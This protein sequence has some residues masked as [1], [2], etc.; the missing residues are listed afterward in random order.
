MGTLNRAQV[1]GH[2]GKDAELRYT[3]GGQPVASFSVATTEAWNDK[4]GQRQERTTWHRIVLWGKRAEG[5]QAYLVKG[6][7]V[8]VEGRL[9]ASEY[10]DREGVKRTK[11]EI[12]ASDVQLLGGGGAASGARQPTTPRM[13]NG[14]AARGTS[15][16][17]ADDPYGGAWEPA[18]TLGPADQTHAGPVYDDDIPF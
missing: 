12:V 18:A 3:P 13:S 15:R 10:T 2:L 1:L 9:Q 8:Y 11:V 6:K 14:E 5:L 16:P 4:S 17:P 7:Q